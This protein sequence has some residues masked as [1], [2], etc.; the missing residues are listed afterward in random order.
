MKLSDYSYNL[1]EGLIAQHPPKVRGTTK[2]L[3]LNK[4]TGGLA[5]QMYSDLPDLLISGDVLVINDTKVI[6]A[7]LI[8]KNA[9]GKVRE[10]LLI[11]K[12]SGDEDWHSHQAIH[13]GNIKA[14]EVLTIRDV[15]IEVAEVLGGGLVTLRC[16]QDLM[17]VAQTYGTVPLPPY[18]KR[19]ASSVDIER[20]QTEFA[21]KAGSVAAPTASLNLTE[22]I[23]KKLETKGIKIL[24]MTLHVGMGTFMPIRTDKIEQ[25]VMH[26]EYFIIPKNTVAAIRSAKQEGRR[27]IPVGTTVTRA[28]EYAA[29]KI[30]QQEA[31]VSGE[32]DIFIYPGYQFKIVDALVT[33]FHAPR[34]TVLMM[35]AALAGWSNLKSAYQEAIEKEYAFLSYGDSML[36]IDS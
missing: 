25:H 24:R 26:K 11:E 1:P 28:L 15:R 31:T 27:I 35:A 29:D 5:H 32:A 12:H 30:M 33:N 36:I 16:K 9:A 34:S 10:L 8:T 2:L 20:Y 14:G 7:R 13:R 18:M 21:R 17:Q 3:T 6:K 23:I 19:D 4:T 22:D